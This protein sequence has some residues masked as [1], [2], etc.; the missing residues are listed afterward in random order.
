[1]KT[2]N[3]LFAQIY[4]YRNLYEA[5]LLA[6]RRKRS[7]VDVLDFEQNLES[8]LWDIHNDLIYKTYQPG[9]YKTFYVYDPK[10]RLIMAAPFRDRVVHHALCN[11]IEPI[12]ER[13]LGV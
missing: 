1:M 2:Y 3:N 7:K 11:I 9:K 4:D 10:V 13:R 6:Q 12:F 8:N 5:F